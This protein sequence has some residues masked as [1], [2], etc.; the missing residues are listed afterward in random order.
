MRGE[1]RVS[2]P[3]FVTTEAFSAGRQV[4]LGEDEAQHIRVR[5]LNIGSHVALLNGQGLRGTGLLVR[6]AK[7]NAT[8]EVESIATQAAP[9]AVHLLLPI[10]EKDR[11]LWLAEKAA[12]LGTS[13]WRPVQFRRSRSVAVRGEGIMFNQK[14]AA[15][16][17][18]ALEQCGNAWMPVIY[19]DATVDRAIAAAPPGMRFILDAAGEP[20]AHT[21]LNESVGVP[22]D[23]AAADGDAGDPGAPIVIVVGPAGGVEIDERQRFVDA[24][25]RPVSIGS[26]V[27]RFETAAVAALGI[28]RSL[29]GE[30]GVSDY[31]NVTLAGASDEVPV[32]D[33]ET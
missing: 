11:M 4:T 7:R 5:R 17:A 15:R 1:P 31:A 29:I 3:T 23:S 27:L 14:V 33:K 9:R 24:G 12:E 20:L 19:P 10:A 16:M 2:I 21:S 30:R 8:V 13:S 26:N 28:V 18:S 22:A 6:L 32:P 25:F